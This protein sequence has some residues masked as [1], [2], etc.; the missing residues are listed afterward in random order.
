L[1]QG[2]SIIQRVLKK[3]LESLD[4]E[5]D[6]DSTVENKVGHGMLSRSGIFVTV[7]KSGLRLEL[8]GARDTIAQLATIAG[9]RKRPVLVDM[10]PMSSMSREA[11]RHLIGEEAQRIFCAVALLVDSPLSRVLGNFFLGLNRPPYP[12]RLFTSER[13][14]VEWLE[15]HR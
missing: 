8:E 2:L 10:R 4:L 15:A 9:G 6:P 13:L 12:A 3:I 11:R 14:A 7:P 5:I 1:R